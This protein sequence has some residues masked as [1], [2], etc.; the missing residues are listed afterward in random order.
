MLLELSTVTVVLPASMALI[1]TE[2]LGDSGE[3]RT[4]EGFTCTTE[5]VL[6]VTLTAFVR[7]ETWNVKLDFSSISSKRS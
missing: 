3:T 7:F 2:K 4:L 5:L 1:S 6:N